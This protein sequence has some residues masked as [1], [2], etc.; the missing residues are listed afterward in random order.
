MTKSAIVGM[1]SAEFTSHD[2]SGASGPRM[3]F[4]R[5]FFEKRNSQTATTATEAVTNG[6]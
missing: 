4:T 3:L 2:G 5:P 6:T 1:A